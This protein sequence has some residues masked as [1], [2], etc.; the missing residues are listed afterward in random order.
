[1]LVLNIFSVVAALLQVEAKSIRVRKKLMILLRKWKN[2]LQ[3]QT[4]RRLLSL[5]QVC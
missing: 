1:M 5:S 2:L 4:F 3:S